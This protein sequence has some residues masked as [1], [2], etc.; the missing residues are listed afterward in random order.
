MPP[1]NTARGA[2]HNGPNEIRI[3]VPA[4]FDVL[5]GSG[6]TLNPAMER[7]RSAS[8]PVSSDRSPARSPTSISPGGSRRSAARRVGSLRRPA[9]TLGAQLGDTIV[10]AFNLRDNTVDMGRIPADADARQRL[11]VLLGKSVR[12]PV[13][14]LARALRCSPADVAALLRRRGDKELLALLTESAP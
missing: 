14:A 13:A 4:T 1:L 9:T 7:Q 6:Q 3:A 5:R 11:R 8:I 10:L 12:K 2:F